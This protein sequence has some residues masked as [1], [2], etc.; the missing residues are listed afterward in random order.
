MNK[1]MAV[2]PHANHRQRMFD[3]AL[4]SGF[5]NFA[6][7]ELLEMLLFYAIPRVNT[8]PTAHELLTRFCTIKD[9]M[10]AST[11]ELCTVDGVGEKSAILI[12]LIAEMMKRYERAAFKLPMEYRSV[13]QMA[14][15]L[16]PCFVGINVERLYMLLFNNRMNLLG[17]VLI[18]EGSTTS[19]DLSIT[20]ISRAVF[21]KNA[22]AVLLA[23]NHPN[24]VTMALQA[25][26]E[27]TEAVQEH[28]A[29]F[30]VELLE[31]L[32]FVDYNYRP[33]L[34]K[35]RGKY[36]V[37]PISQKIDVDFYNTFYEDVEEEGEIP[38][39]FTEE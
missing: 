33:I 38:R 8:N 17:C 22:S 2:N 11:N 1:E 29:M 18:S 39:F 23:H 28:L 9:V 19:T 15:C 6:E 7:H 21:E 4:T 10:C 36:R 37:S 32:V 20:K 12:Q 25:D 13:G 30:S 5:D 34:K 31:H 27:I 16:H 35:E 26:L 24:G 14:R 3:R